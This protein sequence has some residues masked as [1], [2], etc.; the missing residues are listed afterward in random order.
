MLT[1]FQVGTVAHGV[2]VV[3]V[4]G[5]RVGD[6]WSYDL[7][8]NCQNMCPVPEQPRSIDA[9]VVDVMGGLV[10]VLGGCGVTLGVTETFA[11]GS[12]AKKTLFGDVQTGSGNLSAFVVAPGLTARDLMP[13][14][15]FKTYEQSLLSL[16]RPPRINS[17]LPMSIVGVERMVNML[18]L[19]LSFGVGRAVF[20][21][22][23][24]TGVLARFQENVPGAFDWTIAMRDTNIWTGPW[25][26]TSTWILNRGLD[27]P[28]NFATFNGPLKVPTAVGFNPA[29]NHVYVTNGHSLQTGQSSDIVSVIDAGTNR[30]V[31]EIT[32]SDPRGIAYY[33][34]SND[35]YVAS[36]PG[37]TIVDGRTDTVVG[38]LTLGS[39]MTGIAYD[40]YNNYIYIANS[41]SNTVS[42]LDG[43]T[44]V[45]VANVSVGAGPMGIAVDPVN[46][47][48]YVNCFGSGLVSV[49]SDLDNR[50]VA[51]LTVNPAPSPPP[52]GRYQSQVFQNI[53]YDSSNSNVYLF[54]GFPGSSSGTIYIINGL[55]VIGN[56]TLADQPG[57][58]IYNP[59]NDRIYVTNYYGGYSFPDTVSVIDPDTKT[60]LSR[61]NVGFGPTGLVHDP[62]NEYVYIANAR[63]D[64]VSVID[65]QTNN[66]VGV[67]LAEVYPSAVAYNPEKKTVY[68]SN[69][70]SSAAAAWKDSVSQT[71]FAID[72]AAGVVSPVVTGELGPAGM[73]YD[74][75]NGDL[76]VANLYSDSV[77]VID[78]STLSIV[79]KV[80][81]GVGSYPTG[82]AYNPDQ[83]VIYVTNQGGGSPHWKWVSVI[84]DR[85]NTITGN[86]TVS[87]FPLGLAYNP[88]NKNLYVTHYSLFGAYGGSVTVVNTLTNSVVANLTLPGRAGPVGVAY[89]PANGNVY[90]ADALSRTIVVID[91]STN[92]IVGSI[93]VGM[94]PQ[95]LI[96]DPDDNE[97]FVTSTL[98]GSYAYP[99]D[100][101]VVVLSGAS[102]TVVGSFSLGYDPAGGAYDV[103]NRRLYVANHMSGTLS[104]V[105]LSVPPTGGAGP[106]QGIF[107]LQ[108]ELFYG[109][110]AAVLLVAVVGGL[111]VW[112]RRRPVSALNLESA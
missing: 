39:G 11:N 1:V 104:S 65:S 13:V 51:D 92:T 85:S 62:V 74:P 52:I 61:V 27:V 81:L 89:N 20:F 35:L 70:G 64:S 99:I 21:W 77:S 83:H 2:G 94:S 40:P 10:C 63:S 107:G 102:N 49:I 57:G 16:S 25:Q 101:T 42:A 71:I 28:G 109:L 56:M 78:V 4:P 88:S 29:N 80:P 23:Q 90:V 48:V 44:N 32:V 73:V 31:G 38:N 17:T 110:V 60:I 67:V 72:M 108:P 82:I 69:S 96:V 59:S 95:N 33:P 54:N 7:S 53:V 111:V 6:S 12:I 19:S 15:S 93:P 45:E 91:G 84:D 24:P 9:T 75:S 100:N 47:Y 68:V 103:M 87:Y 22:D 105:A 8:F 34:P 112:R 26:V 5:L 55:N 76:Y 97:I 43:T 86:I 14:A 41:F 106:S 18:N 37:V 98:P 30:I 66:S 46:H 79:G 58:I 50:L 36:T 3:T